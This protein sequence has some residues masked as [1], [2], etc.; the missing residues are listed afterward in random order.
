MRTSQLLLSGLDITEDEYNFKAQFI[1]STEGKTKTFEI[2]DLESTS[3]LIKIKSYFGLEESTD[4]IKKLLMEMIVKKAH[5]GSK[6][7]E[8]E[9]Y[10]EGTNKKRID[11]TAKTFDMA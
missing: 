6:I 5:I 4:E 7:V 2:G 10:D 1:L 3:M 11:R 9:H 8:G